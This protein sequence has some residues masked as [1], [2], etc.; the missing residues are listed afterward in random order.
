MKFIKPIYR[1]LVEK[2]KVV[3]ETNFNIS[4]SGYHSIA[5]A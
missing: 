4:K 3:A 2:N 1:A 5:V